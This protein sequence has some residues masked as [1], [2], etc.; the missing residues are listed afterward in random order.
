LLPFVNQHGQEAVEQKM[1]RGTQWQ[2]IAGLY[3]NLYLAERCKMKVVKS[4]LKSKGD[5]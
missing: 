4:V 5:A 1:G 3:G 2:E